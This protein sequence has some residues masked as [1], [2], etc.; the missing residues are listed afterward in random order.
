MR[1]TLPLVLIAVALSACGTLVKDRSQVPLTPVGGFGTSMGSPKSLSPRPAGARWNNAD[2]ITIDLPQLIGLYTHPSQAGQTD[3]EAALANFDRSGDEASRRERRN[4]IVSAV[5]MASDKN[6]DVYLE[7][8]HGNQI[9]IKAASSIAATLFSGA[10]AIATPARSAQLLSAL[11]SASSGVG[12][13]L[14]EAIFSSKAAD[15]IASGIRADRAVLR[16]K[17]ELRM[18]DTSADYSA[19]PLAGALADVL[20]YH[21][22]CNALSG[23]SYLQGRSE[24]EKAKAE[25]LRVLPQATRLDA[26]EAAAAADPP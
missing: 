9:A 4:Q 13:N 6:C 19:W 14:N 20:A 26:A 17:I 8:L 11:G 10:G 21:G 5:F 22:R 12:G 1:H 3:L 18:M 23:L 2:V 7:Y 15:V 25:A 24:G 16:S